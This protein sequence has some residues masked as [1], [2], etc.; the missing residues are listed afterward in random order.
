VIR[1][2]VSDF[3]TY[4]HNYKTEFGSDYVHIRT[5]CNITSF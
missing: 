1:T 4:M 2:I 3:E 5:E